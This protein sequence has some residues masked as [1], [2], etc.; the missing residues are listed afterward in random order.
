MDT[1][2]FTIFIYIGIIAAAV[3]GA[4]TG[5]KKRLDLFGIVSLAVATALG[6]GIIRDVLIGQFPPVAFSSPYWFLASVAAAITTIL[7]YKNTIRLKNTIMVSDAIGLGVFTGLGADAA[8][9]IPGAGMFLVLSMGLATGI[10]GGIARDIF[11]K[12]I[13]FVFRREIYA[14]ASIAGAFIYCMLD[15]HVPDAVAFYSCLA[16]TFTIRVVSV[17]YQVNFPTFRKGEVRTWKK[18]A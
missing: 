14:V 1:V 11:T 16:V 7:F 17:Y 15:G 18:A 9:S 13:P 2:I 5:I 12:E 10:G 8:L 6:G 3:S 4:L